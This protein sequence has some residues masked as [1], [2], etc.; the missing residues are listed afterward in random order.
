MEKLKVGIAGY[1][2]VGK[3]RH[4][5][6]NLNPH[7]QVVSVCDITLQKGFIENNSI[8]VYTNFH[9]MI[10]EESLDV[11]FVCLTN[12]VAAE[13][14]ILGLNKGFHVFCEKPPGRNL[15]EVS[16]VIA[17]EQKNSSLKL[18]YG[19]NHRYHDSVREALKIVASGDMGRVIN[20]R[21]IYGKS[22]IVNVANGWRAQREI[23]GGGI[24]LD[25]GIHM[26][27]LIRLFAGEMKEVKSFISNDYWNLT[28]EDN[29]FALMKSESDVIVQFQSTATEWRH[30]FNLQINLSEG[31]LVL[32]GI[33]SG[34]K[35]YGQELLTIYRKELESGGNPR[36]ETIQYLED[37]SWRD[38][39]NEFTDVILRNE[40]V[41]TGSSTDAYNT[42]K[43]VYDIYSA[44]KV[45]D[46]KYIKKT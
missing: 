41:V 6:I 16:E 8:K 29:A 9:E 30:Q 13:A 10:S 37:N 46:D 43:L 28:V 5:F 19:F 15:K 12:D 42:M 36:T 3:R 27:D 2:V 44:D 17:A 26:V 38:E 35:S 20:I 34:S 21:G 45:W 25:Q 31:A 1:G 4:H 11:L 32:S 18:K 39:I 24:L 23:A 33:L 40:Q 7:L 14:T 22:M